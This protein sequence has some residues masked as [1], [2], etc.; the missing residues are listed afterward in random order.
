MTVRI[1]ILALSVVL[2]LLFGGVLMVSVA[3]QQRT[4]HQVAAI[5]EFHLPLAA[6]IADLDV[7][8]D[9]YELIVQRLLLLPE[10]TPAV[11]EVGRHALDVDKT[12]IAADFQ[13]ADSLLER[14][15]ADSRTDAADRLVLARV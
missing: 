6:A 5:I 11:L 3:M 10:A 1:K 8:T 7:A 15:L 2:L 12:R 14:A 4:S 9:A 13:Q